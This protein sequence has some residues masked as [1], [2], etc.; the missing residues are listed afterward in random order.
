MVK[1]APSARV[2]TS[3]PGEP[4]GAAA[5]LEGA[6]GPQALD[7]PFALAA[8]V[9]L[10]LTAVR[11]W[12]L[13]ASPLELY[14]DEA[15]YWVWSR[16]LALGYASKPPMIA[17]LIAATT[18]LAGSA[19]EPF[20]RLSAPILQGSAAL[21][22]GLAGRRL[23]SQRVGAAAALLYGLAPGVDLS[24][25]VM[26]TDAPLLFWLALSLWGWSVWWT[27][28]DRRTA[29]RGAAAFGL[30]LGVALLAKYA[31]VYMAGGVALHALLSRTARTKW[32][33]GGLITAGAALLLAAL[34]NVVWNGAHHFQTFKDTVADAD[35][36]QGVHAILSVDPRGALGFAVSQLGV[37]GPLALCALIGATLVMARRRRL[38]R[39]DGA[40][41]ALIIPALAVVMLEAGLA[42][43]NANWAGAAYGPA[44][45]L[46]AALL[47]RLQ[48]WRTLWITLA[49]QA[50]IA[51][52][53]VTV[54]AHP[55]LG[56]WAGLS[57]SLKQT[58]GWAETTQIALR[59]AA[60][61]QPGVSAVAVDDRFLFNA[62]SY[63]GRGL[64]DVPAGAFTAPLVIW[65]RGASPRNQ[66]EE[67]SPLTKTV[68]GRVLVVSGIAPYRPEIARDFKTVDGPVVTTQ[69]R[70]DARHTRTLGL[71]IA[72][73]FLRRPR[74]AATGLPR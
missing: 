52:A 71:F 66:A 69:V 64:D 56:D 9:V 30:C 60:A 37:F 58:R 28:K 22:L 72:E 55:A 10:V 74:D 23:Y 13:F 47:I 34:P 5:A 36:H 15:Q 41:L 25:E 59:A 20:V 49:S 14:P 12:S 40:L 67:T 8:S 18:G 33:S 39:T 19:A 48:A 26:A 1:P 32:R 63:Y 3:D 70:L 4:R 16:R 24:C 43:A 42:R 54:F 2:A 31:A 21:I 57:N 6:F 61:A 53:V 62:L 46:T 68:G 51:T 65:V 11:I 7:R 35:L 45:I 17:W 38:T 50:A 44:A 73:G 27:A 29:Q